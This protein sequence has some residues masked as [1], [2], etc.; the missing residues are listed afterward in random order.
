MGRRPNG[1]R[2]DWENIRSDYLTG[3]YTFEQLSVKYECSAIGIIMKRKKENWPDPTQQ[4][5][6]KKVQR[7]VQA[8]THD[9]IDRAVK[10]QISII[11]EHQHLIGV[12]REKVMKI[13]DKF[14]KADGDCSPAQLLGLKSTIVSNLASALKSLIALERQAF[15]ISDEPADDYENLPDGELL[16]IIGRHLPKYEAEI[17]AITTNGEGNG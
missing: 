9:Q 4:T 3:A 6:G 11:R 10:T 8:P 5:I 17:A 16:R 2:I 1:N 13:F 12:A 7:V 15:M 14:D